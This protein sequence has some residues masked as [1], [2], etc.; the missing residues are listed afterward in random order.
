MSASLQPKA[1]AEVITRFSKYEKLDHAIA[2]VLDDVGMPVWP[3]DGGGGSRPKSQT[4]YFDKGSLRQGA[5]IDFYRG[6]A[7]DDWMNEE[8][9]RLADKLP[10]YRTRLSLMQD[11]TSVVGIGNAM[12]TIVGVAFACETNYQFMEKNDF[13]LAAFITRSG[14]AKMGGCVAFVYRYRRASNEHR[15]QATDIVSRHRR[16]RSH[17]ETIRRSGDNG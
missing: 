8:W 9:K 2:L 7:A 14:A 15:E 16:V 10:L 13:F 12:E 4:F 17:T 1:S 11:P 5:R 6:L 3:S